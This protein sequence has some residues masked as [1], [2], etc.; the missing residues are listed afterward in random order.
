MQHID[1]H[2]SVPLRLLLCSNIEK[3]KWLTSFDRKQHH[4][5]TFTPDERVHI[6]AKTA[7]TASWESEPPSATGLVHIYSAT[8]T[9]EAG[10]ESYLLKSTKKTN[11][12][13]AGMQHLIDEAMDNEMTDG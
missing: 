2:V 6:T 7:S 11:Y 1:R 10:F 12:G 9:L 8:D 3:V 13:S 5:S 4:D